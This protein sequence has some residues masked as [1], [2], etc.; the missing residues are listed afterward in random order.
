[1][2]VFFYNYKLRR[3]RCDVTYCSAKSGSKL[4]EC[5]IFK[6]EIIDYPTAVLI[7]SKTCVKQLL[8]KRLKIGF[9]DQFLL[10]AG[11]K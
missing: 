1:M 6:D 5:V 3:A 7:Y 8:L 11:Q 9:Q 2:L 10:N 4:L